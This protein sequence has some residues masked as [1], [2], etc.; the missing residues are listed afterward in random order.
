MNNKNLFVLKR[1]I[2]SGW[3]DNKQCVPQCIHH[4]WVFSDKLCVCDNVISKS[5]RNLVSK[6]VRPILLRHIHASHMSVESRL[7]KV[8]D[9]LFWPQMSQDVKNY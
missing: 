5:C 3:P 9:I 2:L 1:V 8:R 6:S 4:Y 7:R